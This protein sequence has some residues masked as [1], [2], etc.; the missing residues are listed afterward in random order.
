MESLEPRKVS[1]YYQNYLAVLEED[2]AKAGEGYLEGLPGEYKER[3]MERI[4]SKN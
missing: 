2:G 3:V 4:R 1:V